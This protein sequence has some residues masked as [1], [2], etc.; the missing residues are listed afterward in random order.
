MSGIDYYIK[1]CVVVYKKKFMS[2]TLPS[3]KKLLTPNYAPSKPF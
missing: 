1:K 2:P 3:T